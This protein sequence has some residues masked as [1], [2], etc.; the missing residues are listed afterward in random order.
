MDT[1]ISVGV[2]AAFGWSLYALFFGDAG[3]PGMT[4]GFSFAAEREMGSSLIYLEV[5]AGVTTLILAGRYF[6]V[7]AKRRSGAALKALLELGAKDVA[8]LRDGEVRIPIGGLVVGDCSSCDPARRSQPTASSKKA[9][10]RSTPRSSP[11]S[12]CRSRSGPVPRS[13]ERP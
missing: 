6:E 8:V 4:H 12:P 11:A 1:L 9:R 10:R 13:P 2:L 5:A 7:R 3:V